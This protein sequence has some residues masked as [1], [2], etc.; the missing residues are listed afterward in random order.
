MKKCY[1]S[2]AI[3]DSKGYKEKFAKAEKEVKAMGMIPVNPVVL[4]HKH[5]MSWQ[6]YMKE[7]IKAMLECDCVYMLRDC[8]QSKGAMIEFDLAK[9]L[10]MEIHYQK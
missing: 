5:D 9:H 6:S 3:T 10:Y 7:A 2:G 1:I 4:P 8:I